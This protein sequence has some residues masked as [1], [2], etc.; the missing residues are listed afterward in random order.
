MRPTSNQLFFL[1]KSLS[2]SEKKY[3]RQYS[4]RHVIGEKNNYL[5]LFDAIQRQEDY[6]EAALKSLLSNTSFVD[7]L[8][9]A[10]TYLYEQI[11]ESLHLYHQTN[12]IREK[13]KKQI[14]YCEILFQ[15][16]LAEQAKIA[17]KKAEKWVEAFQLWEYQ[18]LLIQ[19]Q[20]YFIR[21][22][23]S[24][25]DLK[26]IYDAMSHSLAELGEINW[27][28]FQTNMV[29]SVHY[30]QV[31]IQNDAQQAEFTK[32]IQE[33]QEKGIPEQL[34]M[35]LSYYRALATAA[36]MMGKRE[37]AYYYNQ[38]IL[39]LFENSSNLI[40]LEPQIYVASFNNFLID[41]F[42]LK[43]YEVVEEGILKLQQLAEL[44]V[45]KPFAKME[46]KIFEMTY[47]LQ[48]NTKIAQNQFAEALAILPDLE[49]GLKK[50]KKEIAVNYLL[51]FNYLM[52]Y[53]L[54]VNKKY[55][56]TLTYLDEIRN[57]R[58]QAVL[59]E[60]ILAADRL[61]FITHYELG[62]YLLLDSLE[63]TIKRAY[64]KKQK[65][66]KLENALFR[67]LKKAAN[68][69]LHSAERRS[70]FKELNLDL[71]AFKQD[72]SERRAWVYFDFDRWIKEKIT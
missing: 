61:Y 4:E 20:R 18:P 31:K 47:T 56:E 50:Y 66:P 30:Q 51:Q 3:F 69:V 22:A 67:Q 40:E 6:D 16:G 57:P 68:P 38:Q 29:M 43:K 45:L 10:K 64:K 59:E 42:T 34:Q 41:N 28:W 71:E 52:A 25:S 65:I 54:F 58:Y 17:F 27:Y 11:L 23:T 37:D 72:I 5:V 35:R 63:Q 49:K 9:V 70:I 13:I 21:G 14:H 26:K 46:T 24:A 1:I 2:K 39:E 36:F 8:P 32:M 55:K 7:Y 12:S 33:L 53:I 60:L 44:P 15:K 19:M 48:L 62:N